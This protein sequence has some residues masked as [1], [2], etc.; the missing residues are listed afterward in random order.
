V[1][2]F[3]QSAVKGDPITVGPEPP[4]SVEDVP[5]IGALPKFD[6]PKPPTPGRPIGPVAKIETPA[7]TRPTQILGGVF[8]P[9]YY[10][11]GPKGSLLVGLEIGLGVFIDYDVVHAFR[12]IYRGSG[13]ETLGKQQ[14]TELNRVVKVVAKEGYAVGAVKIKAGLTVDSMIVTFMKV[15]DGK[16]DPS[17]S[18]ESEKVGGP[19]GGGPTKLGGDGSLVVGIVGKTGQDH[20]TGLGLLLGPQPGRPPEPPGLRDTK[21]EGGF[22]ARN[23][24]RDVQSDGAIL[25]GFEV[26]LGKVFNTDI[27]NYLRP[28]WLGPKG[29]RFGTAYGKKP[30]SVTTVKA[31][32]GYAL[33]GVV[34]AGGGALE[35]ICFTFMRKKGKSLDVTD[36]YTSDWFGE[37]RRKPSPNRLRAGDG[38]TVV[39]IHGKRFEDHDGDNYDN[40]GAIGT[41]GMVLAPKDK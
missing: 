3:I 2:T 15:A 38:S 20:A 9:E 36:A 21:A 32:D 5:G 30:A 37:Q 34:V 18:Y 17:D 1:R 40:G 31:K 7:G 25:I 14:G 10:D 26:G 27:I 16:L 23:E 39:G 35:G 41:I 11:V 24:Y 13:K 22:F 6:I 8:D 4:P 33:A 29:E 28:I 19:G 12:P